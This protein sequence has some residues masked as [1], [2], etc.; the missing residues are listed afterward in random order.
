MMMLG[1]IAGG[2]RRGR[3]RA[4]WL[5]GIADSAD[6]SLQ[7]PRI[8]KAREAWR[9]AVPGATESD[10]P[11]RLDRSGAE[12]RFL[13]SAPVLRLAAQPRPSVT[14]RTAARQAP[15]SAGILQARTLQWVA[16]PS[17]RG[18]SQPGDGTQ[19]SHIAGRFFPIRATREAHAI[20]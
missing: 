19:A 16:T 1:K 6:V 20:Q 15:L 11:G 3:Q 12:Q 5:G 13:G 10:T 2:R 18:S 14:P 4:R 8:V 7:T 9:A 17:S